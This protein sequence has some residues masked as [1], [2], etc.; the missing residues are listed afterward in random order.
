[1]LQISFLKQTLKKKDLIV[2]TFYWSYILKYLYDLII[3]IVKKMGNTNG[4]MQ[5]IDPNLKGFPTEFTLV[6]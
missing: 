6:G 2:L 4:S 3:F 5:E 1:M